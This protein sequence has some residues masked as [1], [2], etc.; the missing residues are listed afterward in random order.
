MMVLRLNSDQVRMM[1]AHAEEVYPQECCGILLGTLDPR[2]NSWDGSAE[3]IL[4]EVRATQ[5][6][7]LPD[8]D[9]FVV[10]VVGV[11]LGAADGGQKKPQSPTLTRDRRYWIDPKDLLQAQRGAR[12]RGLNIIGIYHSHPDH[13][14]IPSECDRAQAWPEYSYIIISVQQSKAQDFR[15]WTLDSQHQFEAEEI[16]INCKAG[17]SVLDAKF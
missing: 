3:K 10:D 2:V 1:Q 5:N 8:L 14:A 7:W 13:P 6:S 4:Y 11:Q 16:L 12:D 17:E 15:S 9:P